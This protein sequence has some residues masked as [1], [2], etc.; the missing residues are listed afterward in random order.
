MFV[1]LQNTTHFSLLNSI[2]TPESLINKASEFGYK[3]VGLTDYNSI[4]GVVE[5]MTACKG[6]KIKPIIGTKLHL[7]DSRYITLISKNLKGWKTLVKLISTSHNPENHYNKIPALSQE[8][9]ACYDLSNL[10]ILLGDIESELFHQCFS[11]HSF[12]AKTEA[13]ASIG[14]PNDI[15][16]RIINYLEFYLRFGRDNIFFQLNLLNHELPYQ[17]LITNIL[18]ET[19][20]KLNI[21]CLAG[22]NSHYINRNDSIDHRLLSCSD[23]KT[24]FSQIDMSFWKNYVFFKSDG[25]HLPSLDEV[26]NLYTEEEIE[27]TNILAE[28]CE[29]YNITSKPKLPQFDCPNN[30]SE[31][32]YL[33]QLSKEGYDRKKLAEWDT[34]LYEDR[35]NTELGVIDKAGLAGYF[36]IVADYIRE[37]K[38]RGYL[39][40]PGRGSAAGSLVCYLTDITEVD[41]IPYNL[42]FERFYNE[43]RNSGDNIAYPDIDVDF[44]IFVRDEMI[45]YV[46]QKYGKERVGQMST[47]GRLQGRSAIREVLRVHT[48]CDN[49]TI[50]QISKLLPHEHKIADKLEEDEED[51]IILWTLKNEPKLLEEHVHINDEGK[52]IG[53]LGSYFEQAIRIEGVYKS[54][55]K[56]AAG[57]IIC[58]EPLEDVVPMIY[59]SESKQK[60]V[61][62]EMKSAEKMGLVKMD[63]LGVAA[64]DKCMSVRNLLRGQ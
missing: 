40:G 30:L 51:S 58:S 64:L 61:G 27:N 53:D 2:S 63:F 59:H 37:A 46:T 42:I 21:K 8:N 9:L 35:I 7:G 15:E 6:K 14:I 62:M 19:A 23:Q 1:P 28:Q 54:Q 56:H 26:K 29:S 43:G 5:F 3:A 18:R 16:D 57:T 12:S 36:L 31:L 34:S 50:N 13:E 32:D 45:E 20:K 25:F 17:K 22:V 39:V 41:P 38:K 4:A 24:T 47:F 10:F 33:R 55:G 60:I 11:L 44:P 48:A 49:N 52:I